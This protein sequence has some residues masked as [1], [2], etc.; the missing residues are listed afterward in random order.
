MKQALLEFF[1][2]IAFVFSVPFYSHAGIMPPSFNAADVLGQFSAQTV[3]YT[4]TGHDND[5][6]V[7]DMGISF[8]YGLALDPLHHRLFV[9]DDG[10][11]RVLEYDLDSNNK[12]THY[13]AD[14]V[15]GQVDFAGQNRNMGGSVS[16]YGFDG[17]SGLAY[18]QDNNLLFVSDQ[19]NNRVLVF[20]LSGGITN[21]MAASHVL[22]QIDM[23]SSGLPPASATTF[24]YPLGI[25]YNHNKKYL[26]V[27]DGSSANRILIFDLSGGITDG[28]AASHVLGQPDFT[29]SADNQGNANPTAQTISIPYTVEFDSSGNTL[30]VAD[31]GNNRVL[32]Y[33]ISGG[34]SDDMAA[35][36]VFG[37]P[38]MTS[39]TWYTAS[40]TS[41]GQPAE[42]S[43]DSNH[44]RLFVADIYSCRIVAFDLSG[45]VTD[46]MAISY[47]IGANTSNLNSAGTCVLSQTGINYPEIGMAYDNASNLLWAADSDGNRVVQWDFSAGISSNQ[48][49]SD[50]LG[51]IDGAGNVDWNYGYSNRQDI[52]NNI[53]YSY[54][55]G[56]AIDTVGHRLFVSD[57]NNRIL[58]YSLDSNNHLV[59]HYAD[60]V[61][62]QANFDGRNSDEGGSIS[63]SGL[64]NQ[65]GIDYDPVHKYLY[66]A[67]TSNSRVLVFDLSGAITD[68]MAA[69][70]VL[71]QPGFTTGDTNHGGLSASSLQYPMNV[72]HNASGNMV[73]VTDNSNHR[74]LAYDISGGITD[75]MA[76]S[77]VLGQIDFV[78][79]SGNQGLGSPA[80]TTMS[81]PF[82][83]TYDQGSDKLFVDDDGN[84]RVLVF[85]VSGGL[86]N[87]MP[88]SYVLG[89]PDFTTVNSNSPSARESSGFFAEELAYDANNKRLFVGDDGTS[90]ILVFD[91][92]N[93]IS[94]YMAA[95]AVIGPTDFTTD[96]YSLAVSTS[97][98]KDPEL[99]MAFD[100]TNNRLWMSDNS[101][102]RVLAWDF[103]KASP[104]TLPN[105]TLGSSYSQTFT[106]SQTQGTLTWTIASG[107]LPTGLTFSTSTA[108][109]LGTPT[110]A[111]TYNFVISAKDALS[112]NQTYFDLPAYSITVPGAVSTSSPTVTTNSVSSISTT[113]ATLNGAI[114]STGGEDASQSGF[115]YGTDSSLTTGV[116]TSTLG[117]Q[118]G[119]ATF[120]QTISSLTC[121]TT[122]YARAYASNSAGTG[123]GS[124]TS[125][126][127]SSCPVTPTPS[128]PSSPPPS[129]SISQSGG[130]VPPSEL[131]KLF[132]VN[133]TPSSTL[134]STYVSPVVSPNKPTENN[135][136]KS[137]PDNN[138]EYPSPNAS[139]N[140]S[141][142]VPSGNSSSFESVPQTAPKQTNIV[143]TAVVQTYKLLVASVGSAGAAG[144]AVVGAV[145]GASLI[146]SSLFANPLSPSEFVLLPARLWGMILVAFGL[147]R[148]F[149]PWGTVYDSSTKQP[150]DPAYVSIED[151]SGNTVQEMFTD[152]DGRYGLF[153]QPGRY[154]IK[155]AK[156]NY[157]FPSKKLAGNSSD[158]V[159]ND[160]YF[161]EWFEVSSAG[162]VIEKN[163]PLDALAFD[164][165]ESAKKKSGVMSF[166]ARHAKTI[167]YAMNTIFVIGFAIS[168]LAAVTNPV[169]YNIIAAGIY[170]IIGIA[171]VAGL[172]PKAFG[173]IV[174]RS[175]GEVLAFAIVRILTLDGQVEL[176]H[177]ISDKYGRYYC[178]VPK[179][180]ARY[181]V[182]IER[183]LPDGSYS[184]VLDNRQVSGSKG[185]ITS[186][187]QV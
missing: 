87:G 146:L 94:N 160:L 67:D 7:N 166:Y 139:D 182:S 80:S 69:S 174:E 154:K 60:H 13:Y 106:A 147:R 159:Y 187:F 85:D 111:G 135:P 144:T 181:R 86:S 29:S 78:S 23:T 35:S 156:T 138:S 163:I 102:N 92:S 165:N 21:G 152:I 16:A 58:E 15:I 59:H 39:A 141:G 140:A 121:N 125:F 54:P 72:A 10:N 155:A 158:E 122:Y 185:I 5:Q 164:W 73:Y 74:V 22:G 47:V 124:I 17:N 19:S 46:G 44:N 79:N 178:L 180:Y 168:V 18:D 25:A 133:T 11:Y 113:S 40:S 88:A 53:G 132:G 24:R 148:R 50:L 20:D 65:S 167:V 169:V 157:E 112:T 55:T 108:Q 130:T 1:L 162:Q 83:A 32:M 145:T 62:G 93:G 26:A 151:E 6:A 175:S 186:N 110:V 101:N 149:P 64:H 117:S 34:I 66:V 12:L 116:S 77:H 56:V 31:E 107:T 119:T 103:V 82:A 104:S 41:V 90:R 184:Q 71:G 114:S 43:Y 143:S 52:P 123:F 91:L 38:N 136:V 176:S 99:G 14:H 142:P 96:G 37:Q 4:N 134:P 173:T 89:Q 183:K 75:G 97:T 3:S 150:I 28:M 95:S 51:Q 137:S 131:A 100:Q 84:N 76:A 81:S 70:H 2:V 179:H 57:G 118:T 68:G 36:H 109:I 49:G 127:T 61:I 170:L 177:A 128:P 115:A 8:P 33:D 48:A 98:I 172:H 161:G 9:S 129:G 63:A 171:L 105:G 42:L 153:L 45:S 126:V 30:F 27:A 120:N